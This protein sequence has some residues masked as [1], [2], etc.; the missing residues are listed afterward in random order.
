M[1]QADSVRSSSRQLITG[2]SANQSTNLRAVKLPAVR[3]KPV[4]GHYFIGCSNARVITDTDEAV[5]L[6]FWRERRGHV[7]LQDLSNCRWY[8]ASTGQEPLGSN[9]GALS[10]EIAGFLLGRLLRNILILLRIWSRNKHLRLS[11]FDKVSSNQLVRSKPQG[12]LR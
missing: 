12:R 10:F 7:A 2:E 6:W 4:D 11:A 5:V 9:I 8:A 3:V 1:A